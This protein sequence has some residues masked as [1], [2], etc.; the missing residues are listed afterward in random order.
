MMQKLTESNNEYIST[1]TIED[2]N[3]DI[4]RSNKGQGE[5]G[6]SCVSFNDEDVFQVNR[7][8]HTL[9]IFLHGGC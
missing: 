9:H 5:R 6:V 3:L 1:R 4:Q 8:T 7:P 2:T